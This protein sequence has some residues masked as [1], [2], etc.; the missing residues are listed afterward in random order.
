MSDPIDRVLSGLRG[1]RAKS[2]GGWLACCPAHDD[3][4]PS[5][6][7]DLTEDG[8]ILVKCF[9]GCAQRHLIERVSAAAG[10]EPWAFFPPRDA[11]V[12]RNGRGP[13]VGGAG[14]EGLPAPWPGL[15]VAAYAAAKRLDPTRLRSWGVSD[16]RYVGKPAM[17]IRYPD[18]AGREAAVRFRV[19]LDKGDGWDRFRWQKGAKV[20]L[21]GHDRLPLARERGYAVLP[22]GESDA[23]T[24]WHYEEPALGIPGAE[25]WNE[26]RDAPFLADIPIVYVPLEPD[27]GGEALRKRLT[28][29]AIADRVRVVDLS[30]FGVKDASALHCAAP[31]LFEER[32]QAAKAAAMPLLDVADVADGLGETG[33][34]I[35]DGVEAFLGRYVAYPS[36]HARS[37]HT[38]WIGH[39]HMMDVFDSTPRL[40]LLSPEP[41]S[42]KTRGLE[43]SEL[44][45]PRPVEAVNVTAAYLFRKVDDP[46]GRPTVLFDEIDTVFGPKAREHEDVRGLL[47][48]GH[49]KGAVAGRCIVRGKLVETVEYSAYCAVALAGLGDLPDTILTRSVVIPMRRRSRSERVQPFRRRVAVVEGHALRDRLATWAAMV[50]PQLEGVWPEMP[51]GVEDRDA[52]VWEALLIVADAAGGAWPARA[53]AAARALVAQSKE[54]TPSLG[55]RLLDD[56][57]T[58]F[59]GQNAMTTEAILTALHA[60]PEAPWAEL[61]AGKPLNARGLAKRLTT[62]T[63]KSKNIRVGEHVARGYTAEDLADAWERYL[64]PATVAD[65]EPQT[66]E[67]GET[68][69]RSPQESATSATSATGNPGSSSNSSGFP[70]QEA[71]FAQTGLG[72][73]GVHRA[74]AEPPRSATH[75]APHLPRSTDVADVADVAVLRG[76]RGEGAAIPA[77]CGAV[78]SCRTLGPCPYFVEHGRCWA[79]KGP[80]EE[81]TEDA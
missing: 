18:E 6:S 50:A 51:E 30:P 63:V 16:A 28:T 5:L 22:E 69:S 65:N 62:Y 40:A 54:S 17:R 26:A 55:I 32:W 43:V 36:E 23:H 42:G 29:S 25:N 77:N 8:A 70:H 4:D 14:G 71:V 2:G 20:S 33:V 41:A 64:P 7:I 74:T 27:Q 67:A 1:V 35:L 81:A 12:R 61:V 56:L 31:E 79:A 47:N 60:L 76:D 34:A 58:V 21:Y 39:T 49:R 57:R 48:A 59:A 45:V 11:A 44:L 10:L 52:D 78:E 24:L 19:A 80:Q 66:T 73:D 9:A 3:T 68:L 15:T 53:R 75:A 38:L 72:T 46:A 37:A 13:S